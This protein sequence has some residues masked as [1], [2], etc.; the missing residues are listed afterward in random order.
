VAAVKS[1][2]VHLTNN[3]I[4]SIIEDR[5][6]RHYCCA[7]GIFSTNFSTISSWVVPIF[8]LEYIIPL[9]KHGLDQMII[10]FASNESGV[11]C[12]NDNNVHNFDQSYELNGLERRYTS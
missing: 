6:A 12:S 3:V 8:L 9:S 10:H 7:S 2:P 11:T 4:F 1:L 5:S